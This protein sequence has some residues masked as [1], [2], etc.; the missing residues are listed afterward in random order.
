MHSMKDEAVIDGEQL[1]R[2]AAPLRIMTPDDD[3]GLL[4]DIQNLRDA[5]A[6][7][8]TWITM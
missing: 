5:T 4:R 8:F 7:T 1:A 6:R 3:P 2:V